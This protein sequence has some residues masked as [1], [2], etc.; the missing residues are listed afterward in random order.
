MDAVL[1]D[2]ILISVVVKSYLELLK[3]SNDEV[4]Y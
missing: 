1:Q 3:S 2:L 4:W